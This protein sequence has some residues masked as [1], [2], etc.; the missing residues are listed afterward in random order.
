MLER[1]L[2]F[3]P[4]AAFDS[5]Q[6]C[7]DVEQF[8]RRLRLK[9]FFHDITTENDGKQQPIQIRDPAKQWTPDTGRNPKLDVYIDAVRRRVHTECLI[10][11][12]RTRFNLSAVQRKAIRSLKHDNSVIIKPADKGGAVVS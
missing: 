4:T 1:G 8:T 7:N 12:N 5:V 3:C 10:P 11:Q 9:E 2:Y 6:L